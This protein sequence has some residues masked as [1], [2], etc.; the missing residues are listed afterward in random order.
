MKFNKILVSTFAVLVSAS[1]LV[2]CKFNTNN[3]KSSEQ[4]QPSSEVKPEKGDANWVDYA[5][6]NT[7]QLGLDYQGRDF[8][9]DGIGEVT[10]KTCIDGDT[11]HFY[12]VVTTTS[13]LAIKARYYGIDTP[14]STGRVQPYGKPA[15]NFNKEKLKKAAADGTI[16]ISSAQN[17]YGAPNPDSTGERYVS[18]VWINET[19]K[20]APFNELYLL[21]LEIVQ[22]G[23]SWV[24]NVQDMPQY[25]DTFYSAQRQAET[26][27]LNLF[28]GEPDPTFNYGGYED[29]S[30]LDLKVATE[31]YIK[32]KN[33][34]SELNNAKVRIRGTVSGFSNGTL[35]I[36]SYFT[37][38][39]SAAV[40]GEQD[41]VKGGEYAA[42]NI[43][44]G[45]SSVPTKY[46]TFNTYIEICCV[47]QYSENFGFQLTGAEGHFPIV[48]SE[49]KEDDCKIILTADENVD[50]QQIH[51]LQ[52]APATLSEIASRGGTECLFCAVE[53]TEAVEC[54][55]FYISTNGKEITLSFKN[56]S[57]Q[58]YLTSQYAGDPE[59]PYTYWNTAEDF[60][61]KKF[62][63]KGVY[64]YH[65]TE[66]RTSYQFVFNTPK[67]LVW[68]PEE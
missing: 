40:R 38:E 11:A 25:A 30:L 29:T 44:C 3:N 9:K 64:G 61:G 51:Y 19:K 50:D 21:N 16:V 42:I 33:Y 7:V 67:D 12:P 2:G 48:S 39:E 36:Q 28:S 10:L 24:K 26:Y 45:M 41:A 6:D 53:L 60:V 35:Y 66:T 46:R 55:K 57:F 8:Y 17:E 43:F 31:N 1:L 15:S 4:S 62:T 23:L 27:K 56:C 65:Q 59:K 20:N 34:Q 13:T 18:L 49:A 47:A 37:E 22:E 32:D 54:S 58:A 5:H 68:V 14:E 52:Y 63:M